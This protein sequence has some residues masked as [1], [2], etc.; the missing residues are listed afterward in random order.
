MQ[1]R[2]TLS[3]LLLG[4]VYAVGIQI[5]P[6]QQAFASHIDN[7][8]IFVSSLVY[9]G[10]I[11]PIMV[12]APS[13][14]DLSDSTVDPAFKIIRPDNTI[15]VGPA[16]NVAPDDCEGYNSSD[17]ATTS[18]QPLTTDIEGH[19]TVSL[20]YQ[21][22]SENEDPIEGSV[23]VKFRVTA[24]IY[25][26]SNNYIDITGEFLD[27]AES[28]SIATVDNNVYVV[29]SD[30]AP[31]NRADPTG[32][33]WKD[34]LFR[35]S[36]DNG[37]TFGPIVD[38]NI[39]DGAAGGTVV[40]AS[41][42]NVYV[43]WSEYAVGGFFTASNDYGA[44][45]GPVIDLGIGGIRQIVVV[46][47]YVYVVSHS[48][49]F[50][51]SNDYGAS[52]GPMIHLDIRANQRIA[53]SGSNVYLASDC[54]TLLFITSTDN[55]AT[56]SKPIDLGDHTN[57]LTYALCDS[58][59]V[60]TEDNVYLVWA[61]WNGDTRTVEIVFKGS[62][63]NGESFGPLTKLGTVIGANSH[64]YPLIA[65]SGNNVYT[66]WNSSPDGANLDIL[67]RASSDK[68]ASFGGVINLSS[69]GGKSNWPAIAISDANV[70][71]AWHDNTL[72]VTDIFLKVSD[73]YGAT[74]GDTI[75]LSQNPSLKNTPQH[76]AIAASG[77]NVYAAWQELI[78]DDLEGN[79]DGAAIFFTRNPPLPSP[80]AAYLDVQIEV[81]PPRSTLTSA[82]S[83]STDVVA[84][85]GKG[86]VR[87]GIL[88]EPWFDPLNTDLS[89][90]EFDGIPIPEN[91]KIRAKD[92]NGDGHLDA[93][94]V[95]KKKYLCE[96]SSTQALVEA[97]GGN[98]NLVR[99][100]LSGELDEGQEF[101][102][103]DVFR[104]R[105]R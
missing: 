36:N 37:A 94:V 80:A 4:S 42:S 73:D 88:A 18:G 59:L 102:G 22:T 24:K 97:S 82:S 23:E 44:S 63:N 48:A 65:A 7:P 57:N 98:H 54:G 6:V 81:N 10:Q 77:G 1:T 29:W 99:V 40:A 70:Y 96:S 84:C 12:C 26:L 92:L 62:T 8:Q 46:E 34:V 19:Y 2:L 14:K 51:A 21:L 101:K 27:W 103:T 32:H 56:F 86:K 13:D 100:M 71:V 90:L 83:D 33:E 41:G 75:N 43:T 78:D 93:L 55:G 11:V 61:Q 35:V 38:L 47:N 91:Y 5:A 49:L 45:F 52:F 68:G 20:N 79:G 50:R 3:L 95:I 87:I 9:P 25:N 89:T 30:T 76:Y 74:F 67:F 31:G 64:E 28:P 72:G 60:A 69:N 105:G 15:F 39:D 104:I 53:A 66:A 16:V 58:A 17:F 85:K